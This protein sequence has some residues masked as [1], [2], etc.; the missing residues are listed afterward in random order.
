MFNLAYLAALRAAE[1]DILARYLRPGA[2]VLEL[3]AGTGQQ[4]KA[5]AARGYDVEAIDVPG[6]YYSGAREFPITD[7]DGRHIPFPGRSFDIVFSSSVLEHVLD[8]AQLSGEIK[9]VLKPGGYCIHVMPTHAWRF[10]TTLSELPSAL[11]FAWA[12]GRD[13]LPGRD[14]QRFLRTWLRVSYRFGRCLF[15]TRHGERG[16][17]VSEFWFFRPAWWRRQFERDGFS[18]VRDEPLGLFYTANMVFGERWSME[19]RARLARTLGSAC[20]VFEVKPA[21]APATS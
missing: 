6:S 21:D 3:G 18:V 14:P 20:H 1:A 5:M 9:R 7:Y 17:F 8:L 12:Q 10:W 19:K 4:A 11:Q 2:R 13:L 16:N 15:Q